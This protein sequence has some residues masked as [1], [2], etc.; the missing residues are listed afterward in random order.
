MATPKLVLATLSAASLLAATG[1]ATLFNADTKPVAMGST[2]AG[3]DVLINNW[4]ER[5]GAERLHAVA[6]S[7]RPPSLYHG[8]WIE[9]AEQLVQVAIG[10]V[11]GETPQLAGR[12]Q[13]AVH[14]GPDD[15]SGPAPVGYRI[16]PSQPKTLRRG[17]TLG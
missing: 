3:A 10:G 4:C 14:V 2:P 5:V 6:C 16:R 11:D 13:I 15:V 12:Y 17:I 9:S 1:C 7:F 8:F